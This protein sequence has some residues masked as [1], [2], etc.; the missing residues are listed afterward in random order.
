MSVD[1]D[2][3]PEARFLTADDYLIV[4]QGSPAITRL[5]P[6]SLIVPG[7]PVGLRVQFRDLSSPTPDS[8][9]WDFGD[10]TGSTE[11]NP[12]HLYLE[13]GDYTVALTAAIGGDVETETKVDYISVA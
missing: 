2:K 9:L 5:L 11:Q 6:L 12:S 10:G 3:V 4:N 13:V 8:W 7:M 1:I